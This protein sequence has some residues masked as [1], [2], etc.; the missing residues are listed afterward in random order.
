[1]LKKI[2]LISLILYSCGGG[3][4]NYYTSLGNDYYFSSDAKGLIYIYKSEYENQPVVSEVVVMS[5]VISYRNNKQY[6]VAFQQPNFSHSNYFEEFLNINIDS[7][8]RVVEVNAPKGNYWIINTKL[9]IVY[10]PL[11]Q[12]AFFQKSQ[13]LKVPDDLTYN[14]TK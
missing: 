2:I 6:I 14:F 10:G 12:D 9:D 7:L 8:K 3:V 13:E 11:S 4:T 5:D 1:M